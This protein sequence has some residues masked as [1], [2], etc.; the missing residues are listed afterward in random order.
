MDKDKFKKLFEENHKEIAPSGSNF[1]RHLDDVLDS[2]EDVS[3]S[4][5]DDAYEDLQRKLFPKKPIWLHPVVKYSAV[6][7]FVLLAAVLFLFSEKNVVVPNGELKTITLND[8]TA[9]TVN[10][11]TSISYNRLYGFTNR[12][13]NLSGEAYFSVQSSNIPFTVNTSDARITVV[14]TE[15]NVK[16]RP[17]EI[18]NGTF[19][20]VTEGLVRF[21]SRNE[22]LY[23]EVR[24]G[25]SAF[26]TESIDTIE[27][28]EL[29]ELN[30]GWRNGNLHFNNQPLADIFKELEYRF[31]IKINFDI[32]N[33]K[34]E[35]LTAYYTS[36]N[37]NTIIDDIC[38]IEGLTYSKT[39]QGYLIED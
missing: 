31:D 15:F 3:D 36:P 6:A 10:S 39:Q 14:G 18:D 5:T 33:K 25:E 34:Y 26:I 32:G 24:A 4:E 37:L 35:R 21:A 20:D 27:I 12:D 2:H 7:S 30:L 13:L 16:S 29:N 8:G 1:W 19:L 28:D 38:R 9:I 22:K 11:A 23:R 17:E